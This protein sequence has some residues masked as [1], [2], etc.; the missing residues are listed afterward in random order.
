MYKKAQQLLSSDQEEDRCQGIE[1]VVAVG[2]SNGIEL[3]AMQFEK[4]ESTFVRRRL[5]VALGT[6]PSTETAIVV[7]RLLGST[8]AYVRNGALAVMQLLGPAALPVLTELMVHENCDLRKMAVDALSKIP[9]E[10][11]SLLL[12]NGLEDTDVNVVS[13]CAEAL[14]SRHDVR[15]VPALCIA[16]AGTENVWVA[17]AIMESLATNGDATILKIIE[18]YMNKTTWNRQEKIL[19][20][21]VWA[22]AT[23]QLGDERELAVA[24]KLY[25]H[26]ILTVGQMLTLLAALQERKVDLHLEQVEIYSLVAGFFSDISAAKPLSEVIVGI[27]V[28]GVSCPTLLYSYLSDIIEYFSVVEL[29]M[30]ELITVIKVRKHIAEPDR[31]NSGLYKLLTYMYEHD[32]YLE[33][34]H[35]IL[36]SAEIFHKDHYKETWNWLVDS[37]AEEDPVVKLAAIRGLCRMGAS[38][39]RYLEKIGNSPLVIDRKIAK[40]IWQELECAWGAKS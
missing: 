14:G 6:F 28:A 40:L 37:F 9:G 1:I 34:R 4:E 31:E 19:L 30:E 26:K 15:S 18:E 22:V 29:V 10:V 7:R 8:E 12:I 38:G 25:H 36:H 13:T 33:H 35:F 32:P 17:F 39:Q 20:A 24:W 2:Q 5:I 21:G 11:A 23:S 16:L 27:R 3:L